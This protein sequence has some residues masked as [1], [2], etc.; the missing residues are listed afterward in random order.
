MQKTKKIHQKSNT[1]H[2][3]KRKVR[4]IKHPKKNIHGGINLNNEGQVTTQVN[5]FNN[6][7]RNDPGHTWSDFRPSSIESDLT[8]NSIVDTIPPPTNTRLSGDNVAY[9]TSQATMSPSNLVVDELPP[10]YEKK[11]EADGNWY[12]VNHNDGTTSWTPPALE[13]AGSP[14]PQQPLPMVDTTGIVNEPAPMVLESSEQG[15]IYIVKYRNNNGAIS[16]KEV[17]K[18]IDAN[19]GTY[20]RY[21]FDGQN[22]PQ[23]CMIPIID[24]GEAIKKKYVPNCEEISLAPLGTTR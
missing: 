1:K 5:R 13:E 16:E 24:I 11:Q 14:L 18:H 4:T 21:V 15:T 20:T 22:I 3:K 12:Y 9:Q 6:G 8:T 7:I 10:G 23:G 19:P 17:Y 2:G